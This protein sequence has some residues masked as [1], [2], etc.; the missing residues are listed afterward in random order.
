[1]SADET[2]KTWLQEIYPVYTEIQALKQRLESLETVELART[3][4]NQLLAEEETKLKYLEEQKS[5]LEVEHRI[6]TTPK[7]ISKP[8]S[9]IPF[10]NKILEKIL[11]ITTSIKLD[12][13]NN[14]K[15]TLEARKKFKRFLS[16]YYQYKIEPKVLGQINC[17][18]DDVDSPFGEA[19]ALLDWSIF[20]DYARRNA[21]N[22]SGL[23]QLNQLGK[24]LQEYRQQLSGKLDMIELR[25][26]DWLGIWQ[27][28]RSRQQSPE[29][30]QVWERFIAETRR[31]KQ[32][33]ADKLK[34][35]ILHLEEKIAQIKATRN[36]S[37]R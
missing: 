19:L 2:V 13:T 20:E 18:A 9:K 28:W 21:G 10:K 25:E 11:P 8:N 7:T 36:S 16:R 32:T 24:E 3:E 27:K 29:N 30:L 23:E 1:M 12:E 4:Y 33:E 26:R 31:V 6:L 35:D 14:K 37:G 15:L 34:G 22:T 5:N 17:I